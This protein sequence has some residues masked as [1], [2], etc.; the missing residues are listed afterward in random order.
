MRPTAR[1]TEMATLAFAWVLSHPDVTGAVCGP[2]R[3]EHLEP[4]LR[5]LELPLSPS[6]RER[7]GSF[8]R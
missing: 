2:S 8:L 1:G 6:E 5:A 4:V 3:P 7:I